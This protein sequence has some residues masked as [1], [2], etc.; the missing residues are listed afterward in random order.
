MPQQPLAQ[1]LALL[2]PSA[3]K[4]SIYKGFAALGHQF[5]VS[6]FPGA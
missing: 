3:E 2:L 5:A 4:P 1:V 6:P